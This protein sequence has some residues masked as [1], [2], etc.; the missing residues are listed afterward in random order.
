M[1]YT[2]QDTINEYLT[3][4]YTIPDW[5]LSLIDEEIEDRIGTTFGNATP[6]T[7][8][9]DGSGENFLDLD[10]G[11]IQSISAITIVD[12]AVDMDNVLIYNDGGYLRFKTSDDIV[13]STD[14]PYDSM[15]FSEGYQ[16][17]E[18]TGIFGE[19]SVPLRV[20]ELATLLIIQKIQQVQP[21][22]VK[23]LDSEK[24]D[25]YA[26]TIGRGGQ[27]GRPP[28]YQDRINEL[29]KQLGGD[30]SSVEAV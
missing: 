23:S 28:T 14:Y 7:I 27:I 16:N 13:T 12:E 8:V 25:T 24:L 17:I 22:I 30:Q 4:S 2:D 5:W 19:S 1:S 11:Y 20:K 21:D 3:E 26:Y 10:K 6:E 15:V 9:L 18:I 29:W